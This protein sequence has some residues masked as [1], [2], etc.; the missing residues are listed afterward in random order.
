V[1]ANVFAVIANE[2]C[3]VSKRRSDSVGDSSGGISAGGIGRL[4]EFCQ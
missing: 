4:S 1:L 3:S 2:S